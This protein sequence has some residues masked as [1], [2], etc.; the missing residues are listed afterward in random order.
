M[1][2]RA[3]VLGDEPFQHEV[4]THLGEAELLAGRFDAAG[5]WIAQARELGEQLGTGTA[6]ETWLAGMLDA[7]VG[8]LDAAAA[9][10][11]EGLRQAEETGEPWLRR[12]NLLLGGFAALAAGRF[13]DVGRARTPRSPT[14]MDATGLVEPLGTRFEADWVEAAVGCRRSRHRRGA[15]SSGWRHGTAGCRGRGRR[16]DWRAVGCCSPAQQDVRSTMRSTP[17]SPRAPRCRSTSC[18]FERARCL[19]VVGQAAPAAAPQDARRATRSPRRPP[20]STR[21]AP[22]RSPTAR[23]PRSPASAADR[24]HRTA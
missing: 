2:D 4:I 24:L 14:T 15:P 10:A 23:V 3:G 13:A 21:S 11:A 8:R 22:P 20:S 9:I 19:L 18:P 17:S 5:R 7:H 12:I 16:S 1:L 6:A